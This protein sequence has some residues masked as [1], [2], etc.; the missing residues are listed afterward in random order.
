MLGLSERNQRRQKDK[1]ISAA[2]SMAGM[3][4]LLHYFSKEDSTSTAAV[5][6]T[7]VSFPQ[8]KSVNTYPLYMI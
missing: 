7:A 5:D 4:N 8:R 1:N 2:A 6:R 3:K